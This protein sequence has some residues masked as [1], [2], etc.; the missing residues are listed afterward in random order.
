MGLPQHWPDQGSQSLS[1][2]PCI[3]AGLL[4]VRQ[5]AQDA[6]SQD[7]ALLGRSW[8]NQLSSPTE[9]DDFIFVPWED[10]K[11]YKDEALSDH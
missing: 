8:G 9:E 4:L 2:F 7:M 6:H 1:G 3:S 10:G 5:D 11:I